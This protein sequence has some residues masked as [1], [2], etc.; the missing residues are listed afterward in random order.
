ME[1]VGQMLGHKSIRSTQHYAR[2]TDTKVRV[3]MQQLKAKYTEDL[4]QLNNFDD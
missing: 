1:T 2:V 3:D 4:L